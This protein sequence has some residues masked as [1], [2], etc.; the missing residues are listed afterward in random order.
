MTWLTTGG[1]WASPPLLQAW[2]MM[3]AEC[4]ETWG[5]LCSQ[6]EQPRGSPHMC[7]L[8]IDQGEG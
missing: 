5:L 7:G 3:P 8:R 6:A 1:A 2:G 4:G